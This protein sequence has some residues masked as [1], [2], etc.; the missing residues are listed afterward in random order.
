MVLVSKN[1]LKRIEN[2]YFYFKAILIINFHKL[3]IM[4]C[5][6]I[7]KITYLILSF[8]AQCKKTE[9]LPI[10]EVVLSSVLT[11]I[12]IAEASVDNESTEM[13]DSITRLYYPQIFEHH[14]IQQWQFDTSMSVL[15]R[16]PVKM[17]RIYKKILDN[18]KK[19][20]T[21]DS[22]AKKN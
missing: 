19:K 1:V 13:K 3:L 16:D 8:T 11:D 6:R 2:G 9:K 18:I 15:S 20:N 22:L 4:K 12:H 7:N 17:E 14:G 21:P 5:L 10:D